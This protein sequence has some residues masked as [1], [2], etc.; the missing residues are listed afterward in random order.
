MWK[1]V[2]AIDVTAWMLA[3]GLSGIAELMGWDD[4]FQWPLAIL[5]MLHI[6]ALCLGVVGAIL[7]VVWHWALR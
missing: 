7:Y 3:F 1:F 6:G 5:A 4:D 2:I